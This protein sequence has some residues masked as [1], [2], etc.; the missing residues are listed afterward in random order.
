MTTTSPLGTTTTQVIPPGSTI[1]QSGGDL[2]SIDPTAIFQ[3]GGVFTISGHVAASSGVQ[4]VTISAVIDGAADPTVLGTAA[5]AADGSYAFLDHVGAH[6]QGFIT[7]TETD[8]S[9]GSLAV[10]SPYSLQAGLHSPGGFVTEQDLYTPDG[11]DFVSLTQYRPGGVSRVDVHDAGQTFKADYYTTFNNRGAP[12]NTFVFS[13]G[14]ASSV[15]HGFRASGADHDTVSLPSADFQD[16]A[17]V[18]ANTQNARGGAV[19]TD[20]TTGDTVKLTGVSKA[21]LK[22]N[23]AAFTFHA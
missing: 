20:P 18:I 9:G 12:D 19:I 6:L 3:G 21:E 10:Q 16:F 23:P 1:A 4:S 22:A 14:N 7:A 15:I 13:Q 5:V 2:I 17:S 11:S 8:A